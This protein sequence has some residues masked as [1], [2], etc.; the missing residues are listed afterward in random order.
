MTTKSKVVLITGA[1]SGIGKVSANYLA[2]E[3]FIV[4]GTSRF[5]G[6]YP[7]PSNYKLLQM[8]VTDSETIT[9][10]IDYII[11]KEGSLDVLINNA[12]MGIAGDVEHTSINKDKEQ[13]DTLLFGTLRLIKKV[14]PIM[15]KQNSG[16]IINISSIGGLIGLPYQNMYSAAKF[17]VEGLSEAL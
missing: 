3:G 14:L 17:A 10:A 16:M 5:P 1:S 2:E 7:E 12:G 4:Y 9:N 8:D 11:E 15:R 6:S 13:I